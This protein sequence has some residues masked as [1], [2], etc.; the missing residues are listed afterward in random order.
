M[1]GAHEGWIGGSEAPMQGKGGRPE[2]L[3]PS[4]HH[5]ACPGQAMP[6]WAPS[7]G[8]QKYSFLGQMPTFLQQ[9]E[10]TWAGPEPQV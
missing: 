8:S 6:G 1:L 9:S 5:P 3:F 7:A 4:P 10:D 2:L